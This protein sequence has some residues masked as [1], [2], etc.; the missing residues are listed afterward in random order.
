MILQCPEVQQATIEWL[1]INYPDF[2]GLIADHIY[3]AVYVLHRNRT[4]IV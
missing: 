2:E 3:Q 1:M 4:C